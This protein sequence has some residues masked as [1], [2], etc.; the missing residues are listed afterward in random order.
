MHKYIRTIHKVINLHGRLNKK[1]YGIET[2]QR[3]N[4]KATIRR[5]NGQQEI[6][7]EKPGIAG[8]PQ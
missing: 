2:I 8:G 6:D 4:E 1:M 5:K 3:L 7:H